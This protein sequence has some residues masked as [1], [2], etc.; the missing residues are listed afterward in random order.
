[1]HVSE[2]CIDTTL[3]SDSVA[4]SGKQFRD[5]GSVEASF[6]QTEG[7]SQTSTSGTDNDGIVLV[8]NNWVVLGNK[9]LGSLCT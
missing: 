8:V 4:S 1:V 7:G 2:S 5:T 9:T 6:R 3:S